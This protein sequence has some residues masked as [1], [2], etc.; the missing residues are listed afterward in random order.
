MS[1]PSNAPLGL[2]VRLLDIKLTKLSAERLAEVDV[3]PAE[4]SVL[5]VIGERPGVRAGSVADALMIKAPNLTKLIN[6]LESL[7]L[8]RRDMSPDDERAIALS[9]T[10]KGKRAVSFGRSVSQDVQAQV[11]RDL[12]ETERSVM[13]DLLTTALRSERPESMETPMRRKRA[14]AEAT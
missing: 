11:L 4:M 7:N 5:S 6:R 13:I 12:T 1:F 2:L 9:L 14:S 3:S 10:A 8:V